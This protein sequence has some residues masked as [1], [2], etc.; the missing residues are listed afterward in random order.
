MTNKKSQSFFAQDSLVRKREHYD[1]ADNNLRLRQAAREGD[2]EEVNKLLHQ[3][4]LEKNAAAIGINPKTKQ[5]YSGA[6]ALHQAVIGNHHAVAVRLVKA[7]WS[8]Y[9]KN[10]DQKIPLDLIKDPILMKNIQQAYATQCFFERLSII[11]SSLKLEERLKVSDDEP[12]RILSLACGLAFEAPVL[13]QLYP[14]RKILFTG[15]DIDSK[16]CK[17]SEELCN[18]FDNIT[19][20]TE[21]ATDVEKLRCLFNN[22]RFDVVIIRQPDIFN[23]RQIFTE[24]LNKTL[25]AM[26]KATGLTFIS[27]YHKEELI[28]V[29]KVM[30]KDFA[31]FPNSYCMREGGAQIASLAPDSHSQLFGCTRQL[32]EKIETEGKLS[33]GLRQ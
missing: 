8:P 15:V 27:T 9:C 14:H 10:V 5:P 6:T 4:N 20:I 12:I 26:I 22:D 18:G 28:E 19:F 31:Y 24:I 23:R 21:D 25:P 3:H 30:A 16:G 2:L 11:F 32:Q 29:V 13:Q 17:D 7:G 1:A 33:L